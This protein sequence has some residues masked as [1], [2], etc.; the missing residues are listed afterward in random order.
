M[1]PH[2]AESDPTIH[3]TAK[4]RQVRGWTCDEWCFRHLSRGLDRSPV[5]QQQFHDFNATLFARNVQ[6]CEAV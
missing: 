2:G 5:F 3:Q 4:R 1:M 6:G